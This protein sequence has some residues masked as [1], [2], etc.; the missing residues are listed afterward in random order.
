MRTITKFLLYVLVAAGLLSVAR[1]QQTNMLFADSSAYRGIYQYQYTDDNF[2]LPDE[3][4]VSAQ[5]YGGGYYIIWSGAYDSSG[6]PVN[7]YPIGD[8]GYTQLGGGAGVVILTSSGPGIWNGSFYVDYAASQS[9]YYQFG[10][11]PW[12][13]FDGVTNLVLDRR[14]GA[15]WPSS[16]IPY[17]PP[18]PPAQVYVNRVLYSLTTTS[19]SIGGT[20]YSK[21]THYQGPGSNYVEIQENASGGPVQSYIWGIGGANAE[22]FSVGI[23]PNGWQVGGGV[24]N[25]LAITFN[26]PGGNPAFGPATVSWNGVLL[27]FYYTTADGRDLYW[28]SGDVNGDYTIWAA[29]DGS[30]AAIHGTT[31]AT[32]SYSSSP[33]VFDFQGVTGTANIVAQDSNGNPY[34]GELGAG[35]ALLFGS[36]GSGHG[37][38]RS[39][40]AQI[41][42]A[43]TYRRPDGSYGWQYSNLSSGVY[44]VK[45]ESG[46]YTAPPYK[47]DSSVGD[48]VVNAINGWPA[49]NIY[50]QQLYIN[51]I[52]CTMVAGSQYNSGAWWP[53]NGGVSYRAAAYDL[54]VV[55]SWH[56]DTQA[57]FQG[58]VNGRYGQSSSFKG[59]WDGLGNFS[60]MT[61]GAIASVALPSEIPPDGYPP[62][63]AVNGSAL[64]YASMTSDSMTNSGTPAAVYTGSL[65]RSLTIYQDGTVSFTPGT[66]MSPITGRYNASTHQFNFGTGGTVNLG[67]GNSA[68]IT[69]IDT[70]GHNLA[71][72]NGNTN[73]GGVTEL[74]GGLDVRGN[75]FSLGSWTSGTGESLYAFGLAYADNPGG[76]P[77]S[78]LGFSAT[79]SAVN[80]LWSHPLIDGSSEQVT[81][82]LLD[83]T[84]RVLLYDPASPSNANI[85][86]DPGGASAFHGPV[87]IQP[88]GD[89]SM[90]AFTAS[91]VTPP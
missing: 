57:N 25:D 6:T 88:Q 37:L 33:G 58:F 50:P 72:L 53:R 87:R 66:G 71:I 78:L 67:N 61:N 75:T 28:N 23:D 14:S 20:S 10:S 12:Y 17:V 36:D 45:D 39:D 44:L 68:V 69:A 22:W 5:V 55:L 54:T 40:G 77:P 21:L 16:N 51:G 2:V 65:G 89:I 83:Y 56:W 19:E 24:P 70:G 62:K 7:A 81:A 52:P 80:W 30:A 4:T 35:I 59:N 91:P 15:A 79:R 48:T 84:H 90:G 43:F 85:V 64:W 42:A 82:M 29:A 86:L 3:S 49:T 74:F 31:S 38:L 60:N 76:Q 8:D 27:N 13:W 1:A 47:F 9:G 32:G 46:G 63:V 11:S 41:S 26:T 18:A 73:S 34:P